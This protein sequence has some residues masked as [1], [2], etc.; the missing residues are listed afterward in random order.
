MSATPVLDL[1]TDPKRW[2][3]GTLARDDRGV[4]TCVDDPKAVCWCLM[5][6]L[7]KCYLSGN[8]ADAIERLANVLTAMGIPSLVAFNDHPDTTHAMVLHAL[9][10][11]EL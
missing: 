8:Y 3:K 11:A 7:H 4:P 2:T 10:R 9:Q 5:G 6:A 1:L